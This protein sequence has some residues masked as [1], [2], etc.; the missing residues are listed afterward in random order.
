MSGSCTVKTCWMRLP[1]FR[2]VGDNLKDRFD[3]ASRVMVSN[4]LR[5]TAENSV[6]SGRISNVKTVSNVASSPNS[7]SSN[8]IHVRANSHQKKINR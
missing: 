2:I 3:A 8:S 5:P 6:N 7:V 1:N 4:S